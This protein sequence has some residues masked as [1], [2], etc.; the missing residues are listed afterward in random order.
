MTDQET[1]LRFESRHVS[2]GAAGISCRC[3]QGDVRLTA[4]PPVRVYLLVKYRIT[5]VENKMK[6][7]APLQSRGV[8]ILS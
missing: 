5:W 7:G 6:G 2:L 3:L 8:I 1:F 4:R